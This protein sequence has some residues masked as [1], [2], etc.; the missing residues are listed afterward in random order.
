MEQKDTLTDRLKDYGFAG[1]FYLAGVTADSL[2]T[3]YNANMNGTSIEAN[4]IPK[5][6][7]DHLGIEEGLLVKN[8]IV[9][10]IVL[11]IAY[12]GRRAFS[13]SSKSFLY[14]LG[15][16]HFLGAAT[17]LPYIMKDYF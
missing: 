10:G 16:A 8:A 7:M 15:T 1:L 13:M 2:A 17:H 4:P 11:P 14:L 9:V 3:A 12:R 5:Y 6:F